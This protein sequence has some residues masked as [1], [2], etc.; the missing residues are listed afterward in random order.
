[1][2]KTLKLLILSDIFVFS[3]FGLI[4]PILAIFIND[5][6]VGGSISS[7]GLASAIFLVTHSILQIG[8]AYK[9]NPKD[10]IWMLILG[11]AIISLI[12]FGYIFSTR[13][14]H[15]YLIQLV[16][17]IGAAF[18]YPSWASL[19]TANLEDGKRGLQWSVYSSSVGIGTAITAAVGGL[20]AQ[21][22]SFEL[23]FVLTGIISL[24]GLFILFK[25]EK[26]ALRKI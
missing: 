11:T 17:G 25:L 2:N 4:S 13:V 22:V 26:K 19:F 8:F 18:A 12:P 10:R 24:F 14:W 21:R 6:L 1:M 9:F 20:L 7:A 5:H 16:Y 23:V 15:V 3:G